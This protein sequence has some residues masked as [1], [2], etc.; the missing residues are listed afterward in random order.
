VAG[1]SELVKGGR[2]IALRSPP[3][4]TYRGGEYSGVNASAARG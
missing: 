1:C 4:V 2:D 3:C